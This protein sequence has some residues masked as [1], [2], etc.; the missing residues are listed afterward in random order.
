MKAQPQKVK[1]YTYNYA[2]C[3]MECYITA[4]DPSD[5]QE[6][7]SSDHETAVTAGLK[8]EDSEVKSLSALS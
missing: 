7:L 5:L 8:P 6:G 3:V 2:M 1:V 4:D